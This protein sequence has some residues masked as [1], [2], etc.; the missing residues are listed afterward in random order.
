MSDGTLNAQAG[1]APSA[2]PAAAAPLLEVRSL[3]KSFGGARALQD[4][5]LTIHPGEVHGLLGENGSGKS[6]LIKIL[7]GF[8]APDKGELLVRGGRVSLPLAPGRF[9]ELGMGFVHQD[10]GLLPALSVTENMRLGSFLSRTLVVWPKE[11]SQVQQTFARYG[12]TIDPRAPVAALTPVQRAQLAIVRALEQIASSGVQQPILFLDEPTVFLPR[13]ETAGLF[14][15][16]RDV[17]ARGGAVVFVSHDLDEVLEVTDRVSVLRDG[18]LVGELAT[19]Q[20]TAERLIELIV[21]RALTREEVAADLE[22]APEEPAGAVRVQGLSGALVRSVEFTIQPGEVLGLS[23]LAGSGFDEIPGLLFGASQASEGQLTIAGERFD[24][25]Q[26][27][28][29]QAIAAGLALIPADRQR[30]GAVLTLSV[31]DNVTIG[32]LQRFLRAVLLDRARMRSDTQ[33]LLER[34]AVRPAQARLTFGALSGGNQQKALVAKWLALGPRLLLLDEPTQGVDVGARRQI[35]AYIREIASRG[36]SVLVASADHEQLAEICDRV[37]IFA[38][39]R[40]VHEL[41]GEQCNKERITETCL[42]A[43]RVSAESSLLGATQEV[44]R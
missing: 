29:S 13:S 12:L 14:R 42:G 20:A 33:Q 31:D 10:L 21:G 22:I 32:R 9:R 41:S 4:L 43:T 15:L 25:R 36:C 17:A 26:L 2:R 6:T 18:R 34:F 24:L 35:F 8:H 7:A 40:I 3:S 28:P 30:D 11:W 16:L 38:D 23:G 37:L 39:G 19:A 44:K 1:R 5:S 27:T